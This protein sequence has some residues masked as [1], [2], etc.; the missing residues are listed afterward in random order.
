M[1]VHGS[2]TVREETPHANRLTRTG[3]IVNVL[4]RRAESRINDPSLDPE[5]RAILRY[6]LETHD[7]WLAKL[8]RY[9]DEGELIDEAYGYS[10][11]T[12]SDDDYSDEDRI[13]ALTEIIC[14]EGDEVGTKSGALLLLM[15]TLEDATHPRALANLAKHLAFTRCGELNFNGI[16]DAQIV[17]LESELLGIEVS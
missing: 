3:T 1:T 17:V 5:S 6:A 13:E 7:P 16:V 11:T 9:A 15:A 10:E 12:S 14:R 2:A 4:K 8:V